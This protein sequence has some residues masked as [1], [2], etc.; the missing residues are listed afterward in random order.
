MVQ[1]KQEIEEL[2]EGSKLNALRQLMFG[3]DDQDLERLHMLIRDPHALA[4]EI[5]DLLPYA[6]RRL[7]EKGEITIDSLLPIVEDAMHKS[8]QNNPKK[9]ADILFP[10]MG[11]A[12]RKAV[13][14][15]LKRMIAAIN[16]SLES[17]LS[18]K[19]IK[20]RLQAL[21]SKR[22]Y[23]EILLANTYIYHVSHV[24]LIHRE[25]GILL[26]QEIA[27]ESQHLE[28]DMI[29][30]MLTAIRDFV[31]D[32]FSGNEEASLENI[33]VGSMNIFID[34]GPYAIIAAIVEGNPPADF[35]LT[36][37]ETLEAV[38]FNHTTDLE[39]FEGE[40][41][42]FLHTSKFLKNCLIRERKKKKNAIPWPLILIASLIAGLIIWWGYQNY[43]KRMA[44]QNLVDQISS[45]DGYII[46]QAAKKGSTYSITALRDPDADSIDGFIA[47]S[48]LPKEKI[49]IHLESYISLDSS[50]LIKRA[51]HKLQAPKTVQ[52][53]V[54]D[55]I[56]IVTG[57][58]DHE[59]IS[60]LENNYF[61][62]IG[63]TGI[64]TSGLETSQEISQ[65]LDWI[66]PEIE[67]KTFIFDINVVEVNE[68]QQQTF[69]SLVR[70]AI[71][72]DD[73]NRINNK[74]LRIYVRSYTSRDG[75]V[76]ANLKVAVR[77]AEAFANMLSK[78]GISE[79]LLEAQVKFLEETDNKALL[80]TVQFEVF[81]KTGK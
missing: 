63:I 11:P 52:F 25:T 67:R 3:L 76:E 31:K 6:I 69:D 7:V 15:D 10:V 49:N 27:P 45:T 47:A 79:D 13:S 42:I 17:G 29:S 4:G 26:N 75:N 70:A 72:L 40:T 5:S 81:E 66:I 2:L 74:S 71:H 35:R 39:K 24:F 19:T 68:L 58:A 18:P 32:S 77:R 54:T 38:H 73:Y 64:N 80:R 62:V 14:E 12:I 44:F 30:A 50:I 8:V 53:A 20:W 65:N 48:I 37:T 23:T 41:K 61:K 56:L 60:F 57:K 78:A 36:M 43:S 1:R 21:A 46:T 34:Q 28:S 33:Q 22:S 51:T 59:W 9:L 55:N 16:T